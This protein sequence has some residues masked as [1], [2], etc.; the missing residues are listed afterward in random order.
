MLRTK[1]I[2]HHSNGQD[3]FRWR[4]GEV[5]RIEG[6]SDAVF[7]FAL[8]L[9]VVSLEVPQ[10]FGELLERM[11]GFPAFAVCFAVLTHIWY[12]H[13][14]Y[15]RRY[16]LQDALTTT[17]N[18]ALLFVVL[19]YVYPLKFMFGIVL[20]I[21]T[22]Q[23]IVVKLASGQME[24]AI[25]D[26]EMRTLFT[27]YGLGYI[28]VN[29]LIALMYLHAYS[30][31]TQLELTRLELFDTTREIMDNVCFSAV[32]V[33]SIILAQTL[34]MEK[35]GWAGL[36]YFALGL[37]GFARGTIAGFHRRALQTRLKKEA[38]EPSPAR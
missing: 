9:L 22:G 38:L 15:F 21:F 16:G 1:L 28:A 10:T 6:F 12:R 13:Y 35:L 34:P 8:T 7:A 33:A 36:I 23:S 29:A 18:A 30:R 5:M 24:S 4:G 3:A 19:F 31:R 27:V 14:L 2:E 37:V 17:Y 20:K 26:H 25:Q 11:K 32:A